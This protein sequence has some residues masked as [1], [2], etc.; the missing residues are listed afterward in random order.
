MHTDALPELIARVNSSLDVGEVL[1][2]AMAVC[3][4][5]TGCEGALV[6]L[7]DVEQQRLVVRGAVEGYRHW[8][9]SFGLELGEGL[10]GWT[11]L[12]RRVGI[13]SEDARSDP[14]Y[15]AFPEL[16]DARFESV[17]TVPVIG[18]EEQLVGVLTLHTRAPHEFSRDDIATLETIASLVAGAVENARLHEQAV[19]TMK[20]FRSLAD[21]SRQMASAGRAPQTL[22]RLALT[23]LELLDAAL[24][25]VLRSDEQRAQLVVE[26]WV[27][28]GPRI[29]AEAVPLGSRW[30]RLLG[31]EP[32]SFE[33]AADDP[34][35]G[36][37]GVRLAARSLFAAP[38]VLDQEP[39][40][41]LCCLAL[42]R[43][44][45]GDESL[46]L[47]GTIA[48][49]VALALERRRAAAADE[50]RKRVR[51]LF[52]ALRAGERPR[53]LTDS[54]SY[55]VVVAESDGATAPD[56]ARV[57]A[58]LTERFPGAMVDAERAFTALMPVHSKRWDALL[59]RALGE[60][61]GRDTVAGY[62]ES[63]R[64]DGDVGAA[65]RQ[66]GMACAVAR[67]SGQA[68]RVRGY[69]S[70]GAQRYLW[71]ISQERDPGPLELALDQLR[72]RDSRHGGDLFRTLE[73]Y[74]EHQGNAQQ[75]AAAL[76]VHRNTLR[77]RLR[78]IAEVIGVDPA[79]PST[80]FDVQLA[81]RLIR[82][83]ELGQTRA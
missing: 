9:G 26:T 2:D 14:R 6:Y 44:A 8:V 47:L 24:V 71:T 41:L 50:G 53:E 25:V 57:G 18:R 34:L 10:T 20:V 45:L 21:L 43:R 19:R 3:A 64:A 75:T 12:N 30:S 56:W 52:D 32:A 74:L 73:S 36:E 27:G 82:F 33:L 15:K 22:Q 35:L 81:V 40:G 31:S 13:I 61:L 78:R 60:A 42:E 72:D 76:Y 28:D 11:A 17:V 66:A 54:V 51:E 77:Q 63:V 80:A 83:R 58:A 69:G 39:I 23:A 59:E 70:L 16:N 48:N 7:W 29:R 65:F 5:A 67:A 68:R 1:D 49:H 62:S 46:E 37:L 4:E 55:V 79:D 38:C